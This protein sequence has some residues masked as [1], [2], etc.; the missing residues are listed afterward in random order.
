MLRQKSLL[1]SLVLRVDRLPWSPEPAKRARGRPN[2]YSDRLI[3]KALV[4]MIIRR[5]YTAYALLTFLNQDDPLPR[6]LRPLLQNR[7][8]FPSRRT[9][10]RR[11]A[12][13]PP[14]LPGL[15]GHFGRHLVAQ[16][17]MSRLDST[18]LA[19][20]GGCG[21]KSLA[22]RVSFP[23]ARLIRK[24]AGANPAGM[25]GGTAGSCIWP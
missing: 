17:C 24:R 1:V 6:Q 22:S 5:L 19:T 16:A 7:G 12:A 8:A 13:L 23:I 4:I 11:L 3:L 9:W 20:G 14:S 18:S 10:E 21:T 15:I 25:A 2:T